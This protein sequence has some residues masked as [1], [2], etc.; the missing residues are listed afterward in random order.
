MSHNITIKPEHLPVLH[1]QLLTIRHQLISTEILPNPFI[2]KTAWLSIC[3]QAIG[4]LDWDDLT[5]QT[6]MPPIS[7]NS[8]VFDPASIIPFI[9]SVRVGVGEHIDNIEGLSSVILRNLTGEEL[10][11]MDGN[12]EDRPPL[13]T[14]PT[15]YVIELGPNTLYASDLLNWLWPMTQHHSVHRIEHHYLEHMKKRRVGL[16]QSQAKERALD[17]YPHSGVLVSDILTS[18][19]SGGYLEIN[20]KQ[21]SVSFTQKGLNY[22]N[23]QMT[24][25]Y[26]AKWKAW[27]KEFAAHV[28]TIPYRYIKHD[29]TRYISLYSSGITAMAAAKSIEWS[30]CYTQAHSEIQSAIK[31]Q[32]DIDLPLYPK[33]RYLQ[34]TPRILLTPALTSNKISDIHFEFIGPDWAKPNGKLKTKRFWPNKRYVSVY[35]GDRTKSRGWYATIPSHIDSFNVIYKWTSPS[36]S[37]ASVTHHMTYQLE[38]NMECAQDWLYGNEC[39]K[40]SDASIPAMATDEYSFNSLDCLTHGKHLTEDD[41]VELDRFKAGITSIQ[42]DEHGVTIHEERTLTASNSFACVGIIL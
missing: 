35:L 40:Y 20:G 37:F 39:M 25:E 26:D 28:K 6:Q 14:P 38:T 33:E 16:S 21:T 18:L 42:I 34:F 12:E 24:N 10:S 17:V 13:P 19:I 32:L 9:Q 36:H 22:V 7:T 41:I 23:H 31:H 2:G 15:S 3:A 4:Y 1:T 8:I 11:S 27:F 30:E 5:A 29:W